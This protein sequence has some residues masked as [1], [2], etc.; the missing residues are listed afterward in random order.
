MRNAR[1]CAY[2]TGDVAC[3]PWTACR[4]QHRAHGSFY[5]RLCIHLAFAIVH[6]ASPQES[7]AIDF[8]SPLGTKLALKKRKRAR[9]MPMR[10]RMK[11]PK[12]ATSPTVTRLPQPT[13]PRPRS[14]QPTATRLRPT[15]RKRTRMRMR[16]RMRTQMPSTRMKLPRPTA[17]PRGLTASATPTLPTKTPLLRTRLPQ[18]SARSWRA[19]SRR[20]PPRRWLLR[21]EVLDGCLLALEKPRLVPARGPSRAACS[22]ASFLCS[23]RSGIAIWCFRWCLA[24]PAMGRNV[25]AL[26]WVLGFGFGAG[27][28]GWSKV[29][30]GS[31]AFLSLV[32]N[33]H[34]RLR[35]QECIPRCKGP[36]LLVRSACKPDPI[37][38]TPRKNAHIPIAEP[39]ART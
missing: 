6:M 31:W 22:L 25:H 13:A 1:R 26:R 16:M 7:L 15:T 5:E 35:F 27:I 2:W 21:S 14:L 33:S 17:R 20:T 19:T 29:S 18:R 36:L 37:M 32:C 34:P 9:R 8:T 12:L 10:R 3:A 28:R 30:L 4:R 38:Q 11:R 23:A 24:L 39:Q